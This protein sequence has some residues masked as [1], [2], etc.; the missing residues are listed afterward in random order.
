MR[1]FRT[2]LTIVA[3]ALSW[4]FLIGGIIADTSNIHTG[5]SWTAGLSVLMLLLILAIT[6]VQKRDFFYT[7]IEHNMF[8]ESDRAH[9]ILTILLI[10]CLTIT[11]PLLRV[12]GALLASGNIVTLVFQRKYRAKWN[13]L[14]DTY[15]FAR[16]EELAVLLLKD[17][18]PA[19]VSAPEA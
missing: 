18:E 7:W 12:A 8:R 9:L 2:F 17:I 3:T 13:Q 15:P 1:A 14:R 16:R 4:P 19:A 11:N 6:G 10:L 5:I